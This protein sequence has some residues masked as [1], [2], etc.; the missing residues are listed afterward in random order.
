MVKSILDN[1]INYP[2]LRNLA[3]DDIEYET[4]IYEANIFVIGKVKSLG[5]DCIEKEVTKSHKALIKKLLIKAK[6]DNIGINEFR[7][8]GSARSLYNFNVDNAGKY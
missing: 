1:S 5:A 7:R 2:E 6:I 3:K 8:Y 4:Q